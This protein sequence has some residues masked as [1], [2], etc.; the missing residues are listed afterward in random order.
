MSADEMLA[1]IW[2]AMAPFQSYVVAFLAIPL[3]FKALQ[4]TLGLARN[5]FGRGGGGGPA[6][7]DGAR[8]FRSQDMA[9]RHFRDASMVQSDD[10]YRSRRPSSGGAVGGGRALLGTARF[11]GGAGRR[12][13]LRRT[14][15][16]G[17]DLNVQSRLGHYA[18]DSPVGRQ[19]SSEVDRAAERSSLNLQSRLT[20]FG[21]FTPKQSVSEDRERST[22]RAAASSRNR[23][24]RR[25][26]RQ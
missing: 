2:A 8:R 4:L 10:Y 5:W 13:V 6:P 22:G 24:R 25:G 20:R 26:Q 1:A 9:S 3:A 21:R 18:G 23:L 19:G 14:T 12:A 11:L 7:F 15:R 16:F 17:S